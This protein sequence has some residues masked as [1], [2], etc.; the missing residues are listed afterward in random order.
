MNIK[1]VK[2]AYAF[3]A[4]AHR[5]QVRKYTGEPYI[6]HPVAVA[7]IV[8]GVYKR[9]SEPVRN[10][11]TASAYLHDVVEDCDVTLSQINDLFGPRVAENVFWLTDVSKPEDGNREFRKKLDRMHSSGGT[12][13]AQTIKLADLID[14]TESIVK[15]DPNFAKVYLRE[16]ALL[17]DVMG[18][19]EWELRK[20]CRAL[21]AEHWSLWN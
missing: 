17:L 15:H 10:V 14:N 9:F 8:E 16:K 19:G 13:M 1:K 5:T 7:A 2:E 21:L 12:R 18:G 6:N 11:A 4:D 3:A 20:R